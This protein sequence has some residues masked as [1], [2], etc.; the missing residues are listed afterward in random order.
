MSDITATNLFMFSPSLGKYAGFYQGL[1]K[2]F[3]SYEHLGNRLIQQAEQAHAFRLFSEVREY[4]Q[5]LSNIPIKKY[6]AAG[7]YYLAVAANS[8]GNGDQEKARNLF[9]MVVDTAPESY[10]AKA[11]LSLAAVALRSK[12]YQSQLEYLIESARTSVDV[13]TKVRA[14]LGIAIYK[15]M[16]GFH[17]QSLE[18]LENLYPL[19]RLSSPVVYF[20]YLNSLAVEL[21]EADRKDEAR[22]VSRIVLASPFAPAYPEWQETANDL[23][24]PSR[25]F[26]AFPSIEP[27]PVEIETIEAHHAS[28]PEQEQPATILSFPTLKEAPRPQKPE[29]LSPQEYDRLT[30]NDKRE[31]MLSAIRSGAI[32]ETDYYK[33]MGMLGLLNIGPADNIL[34]LENEEVLDDIAVIWPVQ[35]GH[36]EFV[37]FLSA[38]RDCDD[39]F[40]LKDILDRLIHK[41]Y[42]ET[43]ESGLSEAEWRLRVERRLPKK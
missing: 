42:H 25:S 22:N 26:V 10:K 41:V 9:E 11:I 15:S 23:K 38:L 17:K 3:V 6:Q 35:I 20:D 31:L 14:H 18:D 43:Q 7:H 8:K 29:R 28:E 13:S 37:G 1:L 16:E 33:M 2:G 39:S 34:D 27:E 12:D 19:A 32:S 21:G 30:A 24:E 5:V 4:G 40:R 36:E